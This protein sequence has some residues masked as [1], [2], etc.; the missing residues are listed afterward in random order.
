MA[1]GK[2][3]LYTDPFS[4]VCRTVMLL[5]EVEGIPYEQRVLDLQKGDPHRD[6]D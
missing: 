6:I 3:I 4:P 5:L 1:S 2:L